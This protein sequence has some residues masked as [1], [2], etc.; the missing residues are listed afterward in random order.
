VAEFSKSL[1][2]FNIFNVP[3]ENGL[4]L[5]IPDITTVAVRWGELTIPG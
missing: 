1:S 3:A 5:R 2:I 4:K